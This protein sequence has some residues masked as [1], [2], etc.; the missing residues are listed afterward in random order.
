MTESTEGE[1]SHS[2][3]S[4]CESCKDIEF[5]FDRLLYDSNILS[6]KCMLFKHQLCELKKENEELRDQNE[7]MGK[8]IHTLQQTH[9]KLSELHKILKFKLPN[10]LNITNFE[11]EKE[12]KVLKEQIRDFTNELLVCAQNLE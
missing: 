7:R 6:Q 8:T 12:N 3:P 5:Y 11:L 4:R 9:F 2:E 1:A 10:Y